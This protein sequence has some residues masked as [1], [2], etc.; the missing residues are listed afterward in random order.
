MDLLNDN[1][2]LDPVSE[3]LRAVRIRSTILCRSALAAP[4]GFGIAGHGKPVFHLITRGSCWLGVEGEDGQVPLAAGDLVL[5]PTGRQHWL[6]DEPQTPA[7]KLED[8]LA[9]T[10]L[11]RNLRLCH[12]DG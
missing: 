10:P 6:R 7:P 5:L 3:V 12:G 11:D 1:D 8:I 2:V 4:W 9:A